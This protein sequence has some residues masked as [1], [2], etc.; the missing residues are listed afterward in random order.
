MAFY[1]TGNYGKATSESKMGRYTAGLDENHFFNAHWHNDLEF[2]LLLE[3]QMEMTLNEH[4]QMAYPGDIMVCG[5][6][7]LHS[8]RSIGNTLNLTIVFDPSYIR[9]IDAG[10]KLP[11]CFLNREM[12]EQLAVPDS[13]YKEIVDIFMKISSEVDKEGE[14]ISEVAIDYLNIAY[15]YLYRYLSSVREET[16]MSKA[17]YD[18]MK[19]VVEYTQD[20]CKSNISL[21]ELSDRFGVSQSQLSRYFHNTFEKTFKAYLLNVRIA[22]SKLLLCNTEESIIDIAM[23]CG[24]NSIRTFNRTFK[25]IEDC[26]PSHYRKHM[27]QIK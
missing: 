10:K 24:F 7:V 15:Q 22:Q 4:T 3:G 14:G 12:R 11:S 18:I 2:S 23:N 16:R 20:H 9:D 26:T 27:K 25:D 17:Q 21:K 6:D 19:Q 5:R 13:I 8:G 1:E